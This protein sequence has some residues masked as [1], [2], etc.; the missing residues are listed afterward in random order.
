[1]K[2]LLV[3][4][5]ALSLTFVLFACGGKT[6]CETC[7]DENGDGA[8]DVC[9]EAVTPADDG[10][11]EIEALTY[12]EYVA[13]E[14][15]TVVTIR[16]YVQAKQSWWDN[17]A[18]LYLQDENGGSFVYN[19][20]ISEEDYNKLTPGKELAV[21]G[22]KVAYRGEVEISDEEATYQI[23]DGNWIAPATDVTELL[24][25]DELINSQN[26]FV[27]FKNLVVAPV[28][29]AE[30]VEHD[31]MYNWNGAGDEGSDLYFN[32]TDGKN[33]YSFTVE[34]YLCG[35]DTDVYKAVKT[36]KVGDV[37]NA[38]GFLYWYD[39]V[40][41]HITSVTVAVTN[42]AVHT[43]S[44]GTMTYAEYDA[45][46]L[47][48]TVTIE[49]FVQA[50][51]GWW[52]DKAV[53]YLQDADGA[54]FVYNLPISE[55][56]YNLLVL[57]QKVKITGKKVAYRG[58]VEISD[59]EA[60][61]EILPGRWFAPATDVTELLG[62]DE[63][64]NYQNRYVSFTGLTVVA[65]TDADGVE[66]DWMYNWNGAGDEGND[67]YFN[68]TDGTNVY[69]FTVE[70]YLCGADSDVYKAVKTLKVGDVINAEGF[71]YWYDTVNPHITY[72][73]VVP[74]E[75]E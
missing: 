63:L 22:K 27:S 58:E 55:A 7:V 34:S 8:C 43:K 40:N 75:A 16:A 25:T 37:I 52:A 19:L 68:V 65:C 67:L 49:A 51:Q 62:T 56:D 72:V 64:I 15:N 4:L 17:K 12:A 2:K 18:V 14:L 29:D 53:L 50:K 39:T 74:A 44:E 54:Y 30:G 24:G 13:A 42:E 47:N 48:T 46:E 32:V 23:L 6:P 21:T 35:K 73:E 70:S 10:G 61:F 41:P 60:T 71:L 45:A 11:D 36:L 9:G 28:T 38:E 69:S 20:P 3:L 1:M 57:G 5:L 31:W 59:T 66:H 26:K 33:V